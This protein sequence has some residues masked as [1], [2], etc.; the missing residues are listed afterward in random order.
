M[1]TKSSPVTCHRLGTRR[2]PSYSRAV[3]EILLAILLGPFLWLAGAIVFDGVHWILHLMLRSRFAWLRGLA[4]PH[5][6][7][8]EWIDRNLETNWELQSANIWCHIVPEYL[9]QLA[10]TGLL[11]LVLPL[12]FVLVLALLQTAV[13]L[14]I[15]HARGCDLNHRPAARIDA[16]PPGW[17]TPPSYHAL[18]HAWPDAYFSSYTKVVDRIVGGG[19]QI[20]GRRFGWLGPTST[21]GEALRQRVE[22]KGGLV[23]SDPD[24]LGELDVLVLLDPGAPLVAPVEAFIEATRHRQ[25]PPEVWALRASAEDP[26]ARHYLKD[27]RVAFRTLLVPE[28]LPSA[29]WARRALRWIR[30][31]AHFVAPG[32]LSGWAALQRFRRTRPIEPAGA[33]TVRHRLELAASAGADS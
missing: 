19:S 30:R 17:L 12:P 32:P 22:R 28:A 8:H 13:F 23:A 6:V 31:D 25:L 7:H 33:R 18:H 9:T 20:A 2:D 16:H 5:G 15:L 3:L 10:F 14:G 4:R 24:S 26:V 21:F 1:L 29:A 11:A 27:V